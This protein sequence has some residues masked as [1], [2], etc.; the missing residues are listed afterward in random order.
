[1][2]GVTLVRGSVCPTKDAFIQ[3][4]GRTR[5]KIMVVHALPITA[6]TY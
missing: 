4:V 1:M 5:L 2:W 6:L 3:F